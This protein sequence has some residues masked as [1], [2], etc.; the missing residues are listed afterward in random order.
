LNDTPLVYRFYSA[1][2]DMY[3]HSSLQIPWYM[4]L[5]N[6]DVLGD[7]T[8]Q[9]ELANK[10]DSRWIMNNSYYSHEYKKNG[11]DA[12]F[13]HYDTNCFLSTYQQVST[14]SYFL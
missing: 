11:V 3:N 6:H 14:W 13:I 4:T 9:T 10:L 7:V 8:F 5:G 12:L 2:V 1:F